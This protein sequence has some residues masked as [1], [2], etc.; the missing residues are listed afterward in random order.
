M[1]NYWSCSKFADWIRGTPT[2]GAKSSEEWNKWRK[3]AQL[4]KF[5]YWLAETALSKIEDVVMYIPEKLNSI[6]Y[7]LNNRYMIRSNSLTA[8]KDD[9]KPGQWCDV[10][11]RFLPCMFNEL[12]DFVE[13]E[14]AWMHV[15]FSDEAREKYNLP[16][17][18]KQW[19]TR[20][21]KQWRNIE[22][23]VAYLEWA[24]SLKYDDSMWVDKKDKL[25]G[26]PTPQALNSQEILKLYRWWKET[27]RN[28][29]DV[30]EI[31]GWSAYCNSK[32][33]GEDGLF[34]EEKTKEEKKEVSRMLKEMRKLEEKYAKEDEEMMIRLIK[35]RD[36]LWT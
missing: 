33:D 14:C 29:P 8:H 7:Y 35:I 27:Y 30:Y 32:R 15:C 4:K 21:F 20:W 10:G 26:K 11:N 18:R 24:S 16:W 36:S 12:V 3:Q 34:S 25:Y 19:Y 9:I 28:R 1:R 13:I 6:R 17:W 31:S 5:R 23:G 2:G 22:A